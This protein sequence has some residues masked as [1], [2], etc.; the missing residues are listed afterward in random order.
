MSTHKCI[1]VEGECKDP[2][3]CGG[4]ETDQ[5]LC[6]RNL[7]CRGKG[8]VAIFCD[9]DGGHVHFCESCAEARRA[10]IERRD[11]KCNGISATAFPIIV[12]GDV[13]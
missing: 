10:A 12:V 9:E 13:G 3:S 1:F 2:R 4:H 6:A 5:G 8:A 7:E 11:A